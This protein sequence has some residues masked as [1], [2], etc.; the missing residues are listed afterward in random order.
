MNLTLNVQ[1]ILSYK[2]L[3]EIKNLILE[4]KGILDFKPYYKFIDLR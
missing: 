4:F 2:K 3:E 1:S